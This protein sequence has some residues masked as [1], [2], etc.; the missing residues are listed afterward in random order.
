LRHFS[1][2]LEPY[3]EIMHCRSCG[4]NYDAARG[5]CPRCGASKTGN[6]PTSFGRRWAV[7]GISLFLLSGLVLISTFYYVEQRRAQRVLPTKANS[8][9]TQQLPA[10]KELK[11]Q[12]LTPQ[13][14][15]QLIPAAF[16]EKFISA[17]GENLPDDQQLI[18]TADVEYLVVFG[19]QLIESKKVKTLMLFKWEAGSL[20]NVSPQSLPADFPQGQICPEPGQLKFYGQSHDILITQPTTLT[21]ANQP[22]LP[23][24]K[25]VVDCSAN[26]KSLKSSSIDSST[27][28]G[29]SEMALCEQAYTVQELYW[30]GS[31]YQLGA[32][33][34]HNDPYT[35]FYVVANALEN[36]ALTAEVRLILP[37]SLEFEITQGFERDPGF[38]WTAKNLTTDDA[39]ELKVLDTVTYALTNG[40]S[41]IKV[42]VAKTD[43]WWQVTDIERV[44]L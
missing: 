18:T 36:K 27:A 24:I 10:A 25:E 23:L 30:C 6:Q 19:S 8:N 14:R 7:A 32:K 11:L 40:K 5:L 37:A 26:N 20:A 12:D 13:E 17:S 22:Q 38:F 35:V 1:L 21:A 34:W 42:T 39:Q 31:D 44:N 3:E 41:T 15:F 4:I 43:G 29:V 28:D 9:I 2:K 16:R 33:R